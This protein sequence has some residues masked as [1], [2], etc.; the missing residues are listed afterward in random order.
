[1]DLIRLQREILV[2]VVCLIL[3]FPWNLPA[4]TQKV[5][6]SVNRTQLSMNQH[7]QVEI[8]FR[9]FNRFPEFDFH[10]EHFSVLSG[11]SQSSSFQWINGETYSSKK[12]IYTVAPKRQGTF[13]IGPYEITHRG[14][15]YTTNS[16][17]I[18]VSAGSGSAGQPDDRN[19]GESEGTDADDQEVLF[20]EAVPSETSVYK[21]EQITVTYRLFTRVSIRNYSIEQIPDATGFWKEEIQT[22]QN[23]RLTEEIRNGVRYS[24]AVIKKMAYFPTKSG[25]LTIDP[26][27]V[28]VEVQAGRRRSMFEDFFSDPFGRV[29][30]K[31]FVGNAIP[32]EVRPL[33][34]DGQPEYYTGAVGE[35]TVTASQDTQI[36]T[37]DEAVG[38]EVIVRGTG[39]IPM[40][41]LPNPEPPSGMDMFDPE[42]NKQTK[43]EDGLLTGT[44]TY[45]YVFI[46]REAGKFQLPVIPFSYFNVRNKSYSTLEV[47]GGALQVRPLENRMAGTGF[48]REEVKLLNTDIRYL[49]S[50]P[51]TLREAGQ[52]FYGRWSYYLVILA[53]I[54]LLAG[55]IGY[56]YWQ[57]RW[58][59]DTAYLRRRNASRNAAKHIQRAERSDGGPVYYS[60]LAKAVTGFV[61]DKCNTS[62]NALE[63][64]EIEDLLKR[65]EVPDDLVEETVRF[66]GDCD[67]GRFAPAGSHDGESNRLAGEARELVK[68]LDRFL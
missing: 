3:G 61:G 4:Q 29:A 24:T 56:Q 39:N 55:T 48:S 14:E 6:V 20:I 66:L 28:K 51:G 54:T 49:K 50:S 41:T 68:E 32:I 2:A 7:I 40:I 62:E 23:P 30:V 63:T 26:M 59:Q 53:G 10:P 13:T 36:T 19:E 52:R 43:I 12:L 21:G 57:R 34:A 27:P 15:T 47:G 18:T 37:V 46:P 65:S 11:P 38:M 17:K 44:V 45:H 5:T 31:R 64:G 42:V 33:P 35:F 22:P 60:E 16:V 25:S 58:G 67:A 1:M 8:E 9:N